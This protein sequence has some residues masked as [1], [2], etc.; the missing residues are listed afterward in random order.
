MTFPGGLTGAFLRASRQNPRAASEIGFALMRY[1]DASA[2]TGLF[3][4]RERPKLSVAILLKVFRW[5]LTSF[6]MFG[7][8]P[9]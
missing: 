4:L 9:G 6:A 5:M 1:T 7:A 2:K 8:R 3:R